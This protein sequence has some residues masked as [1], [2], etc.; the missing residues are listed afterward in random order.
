MGQKY[1]D[2]FFKLR[3]CGD[4]LNSVSVMH[5]ASKEITESL[6]VIKKLK[7]IV[8]PKPMQYNVIDLCAGNALTSVLAV[9]MLP[10]KSALAVD[11]KKRKGNYD[12]TQRFHYKQGEVANVCLMPMDIAISVHPCQTG[13]LVVDLFNNSDAYA[14]IMMPCCHGDSNDVFCKPWLLT[15]MSKYDIWTYHLATKIKRATVTIHKD[16]YVLSP[17]N[18]VIVAVR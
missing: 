8:L 18:N 4:V 13:D 9:H 11:R 17:K 15:K 14:L 6:A 12:R 16:P 5:N 10:V 7:Q 1:L 3:C 2:E